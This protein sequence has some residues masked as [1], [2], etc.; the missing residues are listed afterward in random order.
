MSR[1]QNQCAGFHAF[2]SLLLSHLFKSRIFGA[3]VKND[4]FRA[5][6]QNI[7]YPFRLP[8]GIDIQRYGV[9]IRQRRLAVDNRHTVYFS[10]FYSQGDRRMPVLTKHPECPEAVTFG[11][12][13]C[14]NDNG[15]S[16]PVFT[17]GA[18]LSL[19]KE[20]I[21]YFWAKIE[22]MSR[23]YFII[24]VSVVLMASSCAINKDLMFRTSTDYVFD[25]PR[26][27][28]TLD[29]FTLVP[30]DL[31]TFEVYTN[32]GSVVIETYTNTTGSGTGS[33]FGGGTK[34][35]LLDGNG[36]VVLPVV[37]KVHAAGMTINEF[38]DFLK[39]EYAKILV[40]PFVQVKVL[41]RRVVVFPGR[42]GLG[43]V[44]GLDQPNIR[45]I[46]VIARAGGMGERADAS[47]IKVIRNVDSKHEVYQ[48]DLSKIEGI[49][50]AEMIVESGDIIY[51]ESNPNLI[52]EFSSDFLPA[53]QIISTV[54]FTII[55]FRRL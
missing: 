22:R 12:I 24:L 2:N 13:A 26:A 9:Y 7:I 42:A 47:R 8:L 34:Q 45:L 43:Q 53:V 6:V 25:N 55:L 14:S 48:L 30:N 52:K 49:A 37:G 10:F 40:N 39:A 35:F 18:E 23:Y 11:V 1:K 51:I 36:D 21:Y 33:M 46:E 54:F 38:Q 27:D 19:N 5:Q 28:S 16:G 3:R 17:H 20:L 29:E 31:I 15:L 41:N 4:P 50:Q 44:V 32:D